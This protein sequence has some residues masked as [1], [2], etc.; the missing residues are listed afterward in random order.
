MMDDDGTML[1]DN[2]SIPESEMGTELDVIIPGMSSRLK[3]RREFDLDIRKRRGEAGGSHAA[4]PGRH[5]HPGRHQDRLPDRSPGA[6]VRQ[7]CRLA[8]IKF[9]TIPSKAIDPNA[10]RRARPRAGSRGHAKDGGVGVPPGAFGAFGAG[11]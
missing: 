6:R 3:E 5:H 8:K 4:L 2:M 9:V 7:R 10:P 11:V 1:L